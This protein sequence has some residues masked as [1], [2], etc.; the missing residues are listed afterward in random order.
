VSD[1]V[2]SQSRRKEARKGQQDLRHLHHLPPSASTVAQQ[3][4]K[5]SDVYGRNRKAQWYHPETEH[6]QEPQNASGNQQET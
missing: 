2:G 4:P 5:A 6:R 1:L 3:V